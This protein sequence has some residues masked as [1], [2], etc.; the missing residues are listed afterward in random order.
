MLVL[1][2][3]L[4]PWQPFYSLLGTASATL[5]GLLFVAASVGS[6]VFTEE[7][8]HG[9]R[10]FLSPTVVHFGS[11]LAAC[12][13]GMAPTQSWLLSGSLIGLEGLCG[14]V[15]AASVLHGMVRHGFMTKIDLEDRVWYAALPATSYA[16]IAAAGLSLCLSLEAGCG[17][18][19]LGLMLLL[20]AGI[21]NAWDMTV[22][23]VTRNGR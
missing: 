15:Y 9:L 20:L 18:L 21:R 17:L 12:L 10:A 1:L 22:W 6:R 11:V 2:D 16:L 4:K 7:R 19:A 5:I 8:Q 23:T 14:L 13:I 3:T